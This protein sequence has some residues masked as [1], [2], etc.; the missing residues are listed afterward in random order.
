M[1]FISL[2]TADARQSG[3]LAVG[4]RNPILIFDL[5]E[6]V[7]EWSKAPGA[8]LG[9]RRESTVGSNPTPSANLLLHAEFTRSM[10]RLVDIIDYR[11]A[12]TIDK[13]PT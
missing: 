7:A 10:A 13:K 9:C 3:R 2:Q 11:I 8:K 12:R 1:E 6:G 5:L 4:G